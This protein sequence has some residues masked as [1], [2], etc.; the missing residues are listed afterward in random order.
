MIIDLPMDNIEDVIE[1]AKLLSAV[2]INQVKCHSLYILKDTK[3]G[4][5]YSQGK[6]EPVTME[7]YIERIITFLEYLP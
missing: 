4:S 1:G 3:L 6:I 7:E 5:L 2:G